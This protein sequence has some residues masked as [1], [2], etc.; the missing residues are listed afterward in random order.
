M[1]IVTE[2]VQFLVETWKSSRGRGRACAL[3]LNTGGGVK[4]SQA[5]TR[6]SSLP[7]AWNPIGAQSNCFWG[8]LKGS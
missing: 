7:L 4:G 3:S 8:S 2:E 5:L 1:L 6:A